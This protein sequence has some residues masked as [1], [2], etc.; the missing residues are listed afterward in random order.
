MHICS[1]SDIRRGAACALALGLALA[2]GSAGA[3]TD[4]ASVHDGAATHNAKAAAYS[5]CT[6]SIGGGATQYYFGVENNVGALN[7]F[8][9]NIAGN[10]S[11]SPGTAEPTGDDPAANYHVVNVGPNYVG[12]CTEVTPGSPGS[13]TLNPN[14]YYCV[15]RNATT[16]GD[17]LWIRTKWTGTQFTQTSIRHDPTTFPVELQSIDIE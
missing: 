12:G 10:F 4:C 17:K 2:A 8:G 15:L 7:I 5:N 16:S 11:P 13:T 1:N 3:A 9:D 14:D 6:I